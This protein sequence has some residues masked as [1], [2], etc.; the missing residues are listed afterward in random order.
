MFLATHMPAPMPPS[1]Q[2]SLSVESSTPTSPAVTAALE[3]LDHVIRHALGRSVYGIEGD[4]GGNTTSQEPLDRFTWG[5]WS[6]DDAIAL[7]TLVMVVF[8]VWL[9]LLLIKLFLGMFL[10][11]YSRDRYARM[12]LKEH[13][14]AVGKAEPD[15][16]DAKGRRVGGFGAVELGDDRRRWIY[17]DDPEGLR[18]ARERERKM[19]EKREKGGDGERGLEGVTRYEMVAKRIW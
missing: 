7:V 16:F 3:R 1:T 18:K 14:V 15:S 13:A 10:L 4:I 9:F 2:T 11:R 6:S 12:R 5:A 19:E 8:I 17:A